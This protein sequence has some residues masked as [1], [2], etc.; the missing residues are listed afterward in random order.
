[1]VELTELDNVLTLYKFDETKE[2]YLSATIEIVYDDVAEDSYID[3]AFHAGQIYKE[4]DQILDLEP[5]EEIGYDS[6]YPIN[7]DINEEVTEESF[8]EE[9]THWFKTDFAVIDDCLAKDEPESEEV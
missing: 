6:E 1:L 4:G 8:V 3:V 5:I 2:K 9:I 7:I